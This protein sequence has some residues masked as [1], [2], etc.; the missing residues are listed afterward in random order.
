MEDL[1]HPFLPQCVF[2]PPV[3]PELLHWRHVGFPPSMWVAHSAA[4]FCQRWVQAAALLLG[5]A[6]PGL[7]WGGKRLCTSEPGAALPAPAMSLELVHC[8]QR[9]QEWCWESLWEVSKFLSH[10]SLQLIAFNVW[11]NASSGLAF[12]LL[13]LLIILLLLF[14]C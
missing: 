5:S 6:I 8:Y 12:L 2:I 14:C 3:P 9:L 11:E 7:Q 13:L 4:S 1:Q 10:W